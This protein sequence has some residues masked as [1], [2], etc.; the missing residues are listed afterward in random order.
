[1]RRLKDADEWKE[2]LFTRVFH[3]EHATNADMFAE[4]ISR[5]VRSTITGRSFLLLAYG[6]TG[7]GKSY[8][9]L[10]N[11][12]NDPSIMHRTIDLL[13]DAGCTLALDGLEVQLQGDG[14]IFEIGGETLQMSLSPGKRWV[15]EY[16]PA[17][18]WK[19]SD[20]I[21]TKPEAL[22]RVEHL[23]ENR[24]RRTTKGNSQ[25]TRSH[26]IFD[27]Q[28]YDSQ[29]VPQGRLTFVDLAGL[30]DSQACKG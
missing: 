8:S 30:E 22:A 15:L 27:L 29:S 24:L 28:V 7:S 1:M 13:Y 12:S 19:P 14:R 21:G 9:I 25:S 10:H 3:G 18:P 11:V 6:G 17:V 20:P 4:D 2:F 16:A 26:G 23:Y 5:L